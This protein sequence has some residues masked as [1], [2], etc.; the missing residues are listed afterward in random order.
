MNG[1][2]TRES[3]GR[4]VSR[5]IQLPQGEV[6]VAQLWCWRDVEDPKKDRDNMFYS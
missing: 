2:G 1:L 5:L 4:N 6:M 3:A